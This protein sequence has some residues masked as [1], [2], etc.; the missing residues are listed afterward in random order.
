MNLYDQLRA[1]QVIP[2]AYSAWRAYREDL[3]DYIISQLEWN[4]HVVI[5][6]VGRSNDIDL[7]QLLPYVKRLTLIDK[8]EEALQAAIKQYHLAGKAK[9]EV[10]QQDLLG[11]DA[12]DYRQY[13]SKLV[14]EVRK[15]GMHTEM[16]DLVEIATNEFEKIVAKIKL[17]SLGEKVYDVTIAIGLHSQLLSMI[18]WIWQVVLQTLGQQDAT[19]RASII[20]LTPQVIQCLHEQLIKATNSKLIIGC[21]LGRKGRDGTVQGAIQGLEDLNEQRRRGKLARL[22]ENILEWPFNRTSGIVYNMLIQVDEVL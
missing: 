12:E 8:D 13:A 4:Q 22:E 15:K 14:N 11:L 16:S 9:V 1:L 18:E 2:N 19:I 3:T 17:I 7:E 5:L 21:E 6:G 10:I 20:A